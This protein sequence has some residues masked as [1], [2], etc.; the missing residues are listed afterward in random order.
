MFDFIVRYVDEMMSLS[1]VSR[2]ASTYTLLGSVLARVHGVTMA[3]SSSSPDVFAA[4]LEKV[5]GCAALRLC[6]AVL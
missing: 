3:S 5:R 2:A 4:Q 1:R 6:C